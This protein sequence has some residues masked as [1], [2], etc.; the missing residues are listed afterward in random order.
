MP[1]AGKKP[2]FPLNEVNYSGFIRK[3]G[4]YREVEQELTTYCLAQHGAGNIVDAGVQAEINEYYFAIDRAIGR[5]F[6]S[7]L[8]GEDLQRVQQTANEFAGHSQQGEA[9]SS[10]LRIS[11]VATWERLNQLVDYYLVEFMKERKRETITP[12]EPPQ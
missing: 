6:A 9:I 5:H 7:E 11:K 4:R 3:V 1:L 12:T 2:D 10:M 8:T